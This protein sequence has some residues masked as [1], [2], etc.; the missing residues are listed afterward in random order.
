MIELVMVVCLMGDPAK[1]RDVTLSF[2]NPY[3]T[4]HGVT[5]QQ[6]MQTGQIE[7]SKWI[8][9]HPNYRIMRWRCGKAQKEQST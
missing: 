7:M 2:E 8:E 3:G 9:E 4:E 6:C 1:C 5:P